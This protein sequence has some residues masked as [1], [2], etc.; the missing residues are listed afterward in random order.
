MQSW[1]GGKKRSGEEAVLLLFHLNSL[2]LL[3]LFLFSLALPSP[4]LSLSSQSNPIS[5]CKQ[6][7]LMKVWHWAWL[8]LHSLHTHII[9]SSLVC[10]FIQR[11]AVNWQGRENS[12][13]VQW[14]SSTCCILWYSVCFCV[15]NALCTLFSA[16]LGPERWSQNWSNVHSIPIFFCQLC[17]IMIAN[18]ATVLLQL[19]TDDLS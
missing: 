6:W 11:T 7:K 12:F 8:W 10:R 17:F 14:G 4:A 16:V 3:L 1:R 13:F 18:G 9:A 2:S 15:G 19:F 5:L